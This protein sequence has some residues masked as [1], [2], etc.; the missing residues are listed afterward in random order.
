MLPSAI[1]MLPSGSTF[2]AP[3][4][5]RARPSESASSSSCSC[6]L[7][8]EFA[9]ITAAKMPVSPTHFMLKLLRSGSAPPPGM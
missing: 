3:S 2:S 4:G 5:K 8:S 6:F 1:S 9:S 7:S